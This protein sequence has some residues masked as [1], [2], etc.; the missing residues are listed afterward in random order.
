[1]IR[2]SR[3]RTLFSLVLL[4]LAAGFIAVRLGGDWSDDDQLLLFVLLAGVVFLLVLADLLRPARLTAGPKGLVL[5]RLLGARRWSWDEVVGFRVMAGLG[6]R[7]V[8]FDY[9]VGR[10]DR[11]LEFQGSPLGADARIPGGWEVPAE[12]LARVL[13]Q[14]RARWSTL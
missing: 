2:R 5:S 12:R 8:G 1:V 4:A 6:G 3:L 13:E 10:G 9:R 7:R 14:A 11:R